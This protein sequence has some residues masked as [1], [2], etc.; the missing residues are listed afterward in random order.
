MPI[1][2]QSSRRAEPL[3][4]T[5]R[6]RASW[7]APG[8]STALAGRPASNAAH[9]SRDKESHAEIIAAVK[10]RYAATGGTER[11]LATMLIDHSVP[12]WPITFLSMQFFGTRD[13]GALTPADKLWLYEVVKSLHNGFKNKLMVDTSQPMACLALVAPCN[14]YW[15]THLGSIWTTVRQALGEAH[16]TNEMID[17]ASSFA[18]LPLA[19]DAATTLEAFLNTPKSCTS[20]ASDSRRAR[21]GRRLFMLVKWLFDTGDRSL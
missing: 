4:K 21:S 8:H 16:N 10:A 3:W 13:L 1:A 11:V 20:S 18:P 7:R 2:S 6:W 5:A 15:T 12:R 19:V 14:G 17:F 9:R